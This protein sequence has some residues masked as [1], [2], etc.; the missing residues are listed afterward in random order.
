[1]MDIIIMENFCGIFYRGIWLLI[2]VI[3]LMGKF[4]YII[5]KYNRRFVWWSYSIVKRKEICRMCSV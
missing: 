1:M 4:N 3:E 5:L 2:I